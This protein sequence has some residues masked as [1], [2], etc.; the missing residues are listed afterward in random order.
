MIMENGEMFGE[1]YTIV[2]IADYILQHTPGNTVSTF[3]LPRSTGCHPSLPNA[4]EAAAV[5]EVNVVK[6]MK[7]INAVFGGE[8]RG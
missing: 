1:E 4:Y 7:E 8:K 5:G 6:K 2:A 3:P